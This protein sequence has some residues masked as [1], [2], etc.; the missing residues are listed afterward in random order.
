VKVDSFASAVIL[1]VEPFPQLT[2]D[3]CC[4]W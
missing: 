1:V 4:F 2:F 3:Y